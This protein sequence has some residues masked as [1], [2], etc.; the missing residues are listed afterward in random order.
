MNV[1]T[2]FAQP[3]DYLRS[4]QTPNRRRGS[5]IRLTERH[6]RRDERSSKQDPHFRR[7]IAS[8]GGDIIGTGEIRTDWAGVVQ[9]GRYWVNL[10]VA[11]NWLGHG[12]DSQM[13]RYV[14]A[15]I[16]A[17]VKELAACISEGELQ[18]AG[19]LL[20]FGFEERFRSWGGQLDL[21][22]FDPSRFRSTIDR[23]R[24]EGFTFIPYSEIRSRETDV[25]LLEL[26]R[27]I[28]RDVRSFDPIVP[29][30][31]SDI[32]GDEYLHEG[33]IL[34][35]NPQGVLVGL[36][37]LRRT[38]PDGGIGSGLTGVR[39]EY[40]GRGLATALKVLSLSVAK[41]LGVTNV[42]TGGGGA[43]AP[44]KHLNKK[45]GYQVDPEWVTLI[46]RR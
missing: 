31:G 16:G 12:I 20:D 46:S 41:S 18:T 21:T 38:D 4:E 45:L 36:A 34:A 3:E 13:L 15:E 19:F 35:V 2:R 28:D 6:L 24:Q 30:G 27:D 33:L 17:D 37:S 14:I 5:A 8:A 23:L 7:V 9:P 44:M 10:Y 22:T 32:L 29:S 1:E 26:K 11:S 42:S 39:R 43:N 40:R 25:E